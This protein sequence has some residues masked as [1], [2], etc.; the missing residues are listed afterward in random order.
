MKHA[1]TLARLEIGDDFVWYDLWWRWEYDVGILFLR[2]Y[3]R[4][5]SGYGEQFYLLFSF[6]LDRIQ[7]AYLCAGGQGFGADIPHTH[8]FQKFTYAIFH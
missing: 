4:K 3:R 7:V 8:C 6:V 5:P 2:L 1:W